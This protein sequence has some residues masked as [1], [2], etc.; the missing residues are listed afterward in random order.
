MTSRKYTYAELA[1]AAHVVRCRGI[2]PHTGAKCFEDHVRGAWAD[3]MV[4]WADRE[5]VTKGG[6]RTFLSFAAMS[7]PVVANSTPGWQQIYVQ[8][9]WI[10]A[11]ARA[12][13]IKLP[14]NLANYDRARVRAAIADLP[15]NTELRAEAMK[16]SQ[17]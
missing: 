8:N 6:I 12:L 7:N 4:H 14:A 5:R 10:A 17:R 1:D 13:L 9:V 11:T 16:W 3:Q 2:N 15:V